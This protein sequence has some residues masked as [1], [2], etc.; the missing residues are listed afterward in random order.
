MIGIKFRLAESGASFVRKGV[1]VALPISAPPAA[2]AK[3]R[4]C[5]RY[6]TVALG[7]PWRRRRQ[8]A[9]DDAVEA[10]LVIRVDG[11]IQWRLPG[12]IEYDVCD[13][14]GTCNGALPKD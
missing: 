10:G 12:E 7:G 9:L 13:Q 14:G 5:Y 3:A 1:D 11:E 6:R 4:V 8:Q 2:V